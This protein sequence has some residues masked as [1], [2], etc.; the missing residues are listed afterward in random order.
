MLAPKPMTSKLAA[1]VLCSIAAANV[2]AASAHS[3]PS[4]TFTSTL[5]SDYL[6][7]GQRLGGLSLQPAVDLSAGGSIAGISAN[8]PVKDKVADQ[9]DPE[10]DFYASH[11]FSLNDEWRLILGFT[12][13]VYP[14]APTRAGYYRSVFEPNI[15]FSYTVAGVRITSTCYY[16]V[17]REGPT[18]ELSGAVALPLKTLGTELDLAASVGDYRLRDGIKNAAPE[19][20]LSGSY[21][22]LGASVPFQIT[23]SSNI[24]I[25]VSY[26][27][28]FNSY[29]KPGAAPR[30][31]NSLAARRVSTQVGYSLSF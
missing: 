10:F 27:A 20:K 6:F 11:R 4:P 2:S 13:Y 12:F 28:G 16:D 18:F 29:F 21:W 25:G 26:N 8:F 22:S 9:S 7:R 24:R 3:A 1:L 14:N 31:K 23:T 30:T 17:T 19:K 15:A 5:V